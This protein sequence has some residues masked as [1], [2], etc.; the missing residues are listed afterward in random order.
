LQKYIEKILENP[1]FD[2]LVYKFAK[3]LVAGLP[4][5]TGIKRND[6][7]DTKYF[8]YEELF[9]RQDGDV[10]FICNTG[11]AHPRK[12]AINGDELIYQALFQS[13]LSPSE[14]IAQ[15][16]KDIERLI[17]MLDGR[18]FDGAANV[19]NVQF[20]D[21]SVAILKYMGNFGLERL[22]LS[23]LMFS[24]SC[25]NN[26]EDKIDILLKI[27]KV[28]SPVQFA[29]IYFYATTTPPLRDFESFVNLER[30]YQ[31]LCTT[32]PRDLFGG[33]RAA[34]ATTA[35]QPQQQ[36]QPRMPEVAR[37]VVIDE[38]K[39]I[40]YQIPARNSGSVELFI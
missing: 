9:I 39:N 21:L 13:A 11:A 17:I 27:N 34:T 12:L 28:I 25:D 26:S 31:D 19:Q 6:L 8:D 35:F 22:I 32:T 3:A 15:T 20:F 40:T 23:I 38:S 5:R 29:T 4:I 16:V 33:Q 14:N 18:R 10:V 1:H 36:P 2:T 37:G 24:R 7:V 30:L